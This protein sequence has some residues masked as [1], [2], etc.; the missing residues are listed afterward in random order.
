M[1]RQGHNEEHDNS[2][3]LSAR[4]QLHRKVPGR[5]DMSGAKGGGSVVVEFW[6]PIPLRF[7]HKPRD[8]QSFDVA[9]QLINRQPLNM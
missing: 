4:G 3:N 2:L 9:G 5:L 1:P 7:N 6:P 8:G